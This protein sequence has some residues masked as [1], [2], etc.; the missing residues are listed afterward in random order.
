MRLAITRKAIDDY[1][2]AMELDPS[3]TFLV[4]DRA[5]AYLE[6]GEFD[7]AI[8]DYNATL[9]SDPSNGDAYLGRGIAYIGLGE[10]VTAAADFMQWFEVVQTRLFPAIPSKMGRSS[11]WT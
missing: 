6:L 9:E 10:R 4:A 2:R 8:D 5:G 11:F 3:Y 7:Q 1:S